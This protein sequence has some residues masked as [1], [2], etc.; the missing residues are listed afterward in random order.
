MGHPNEAPAGG[1]ERLFATL[2]ELGIETRT[3]E[4]PPLFTVDQAKALRG[5]L[6][7]GHT[8]NLFLR[9]K[10]GRMWLVVCL[11]DRAI[12]LKLLAARLGAGRLSFGSPDRLMRHL[13]VVPGAVTP[14]A[15][16]NDRE[17]AVEVVLDAAL[18]GLDPLNFH[19][20]DNA[21]TTAIA[22]ADLLRFLEAVG[23]RPRILHLDAS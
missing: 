4:H 16:M 23:H 19:P 10:K 1:P 11:E 6:P 14:F 5:A 13:G 2:R 12:D 18:T 21:R 15:A 17:G 3:V 8:K 7:G 22:A 20:L 9:D